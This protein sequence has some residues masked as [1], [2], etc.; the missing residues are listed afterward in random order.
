MV[1]KFEL[2]LLFFL[3]HVNQLSLIFNAITK[4]TC[5]I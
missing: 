1:T 4:I 5:V 3:L 2:L